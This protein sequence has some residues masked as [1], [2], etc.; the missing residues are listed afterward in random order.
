MGSHALLWIGWLYR[1]VEVIDAAGRLRNGGAV[2][3]Q[4]S[5]ME[6]DS[7]T[8]LGL[9]FFDG[10]AGRNAAR[11]IRQIARKVLSRFSITIA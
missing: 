4:A 1:N 8:E 9:G 11:K 10:S 5:E 6:L 3:S 7:L 2:F